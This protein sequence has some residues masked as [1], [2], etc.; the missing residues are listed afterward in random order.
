MR[1]FLRDTRSG[2]AEAPE[3]DFDELLDKALDDAL[4]ESFPASDPVSLD[5]P[6]KRQ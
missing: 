5:Q 4:D 6:G 2:A 1:S 3:P